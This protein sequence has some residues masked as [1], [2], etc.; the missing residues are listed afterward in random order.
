MKINYVI[1]TGFKSFKETVRF[2]LYKNT[3][4]IGDNFQ[5]KTTIGEAIAYAFCGTSLN[6]ESRNIEDLINKDSNKLRVEVNFD[7]DF[8]RNHTLIRIKDK[9]SQSVFLDIPEGDETTTQTTIN[10]FIGSPK[11]FLSCFNLGYFQQ[12]LEDSERRALIIEYTP[13]VDYERLFIE[14]ANED[15]LRKYGINCKKQ[16]EYHRINKMKSQTDEALKEALIRIKV[17]EEQNAIDG[18]A[19]SINYHPLDETKELQLKASID[20]LA[21]LEAHNA[22]VSMLYEQYNQKVIE[23]NANV[24]KLNVL[25]AQYQQ[26]K[27]LVEPIPYEKTDDYAKHIEEIER[28]R[29][30]LIPVISIPENMQNNSICPV[31]GNILSAEKNAENQNKNIP[32]LELIKKCE[33]YI[34]TKSLASYEEFNKY[35][36]DLQKKMQLEAEINYIYQQIS[37]IPQQPQEKLYDISKYANL[38]EEYDKT[39]AKNNEIRIKNAEMASKIDSIRNRLKEIENLNVQINLLKIQSEELAMASAALS[40]STGI[41]RKALE[42]KAEFIRSEF[43]RCSIILEKIQKNGDIKECFEIYYDNKPYRR[44]SYSEQVMCSLE[45]ARYLRTHD[46]KNFP[47]F[48]D[49]SESITKIEDKSLIDSD[50]V[51]YCL[52]KQDHK[53]ETKPL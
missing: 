22:R 13:A 15:I 9:K 16:E 3:L 20:E 29:S 40:P 32:I 21:A 2:D 1:L 33:E 53:L 44:L 38:K 10:A 47:I 25:N 19:A 30:Q 5:G 41:F 11:M 36:N 31:C 49:N 24:E 51:I 37:T 8:G 14:M 26:Y 52:V 4:I 48:I 23:Y 17:L 7:D 18:N 27:N 42:I 39:V 12:E 28:L 34:R 50:Q 45:I 6:G 43:T 46:R 35:K